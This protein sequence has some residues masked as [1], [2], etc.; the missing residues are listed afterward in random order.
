MSRRCHANYSQSGVTLVELMV[1]LVLG[2][3]VLGAV[4]TVFLSNSRT[5]AATESLG[6]FQENARVAFELMARDVREAAGNPCSRNLPVYNVLNA[7]GSVWYT[8]FTAGVRGYPG[9]VAFP[10]AAFGTGAGQ[11]IA[12]TDAVELKSAV[13]D[14]VAIVSHDPNSAQFK[15]STANHGLSDGD[16]ALACDFGQAAIFQVTNAQPG[17]NDTLV[18]NNGVGTPGNC[19]KGLGWSATQNCSANGNSYAFGCYMGAWET[20]DCADENPKDGEPDRWPATIA[21]LRM[22]RWYIGAN[23]R[24]GRSL[25]R[26]SLRNT[27]GVLGIQQD[28]ITEGV[29]DME[30]TYLVDGAAQYVDASSVAA[31]DWTSNNVIAM[32]IDLT[33]IGNEPVGTDGSPLQRRLIHVVTIR[34]RNR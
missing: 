20:G 10:D 31:S 16:L 28:E 25:Y 2:L 14:G 32:R 17:I 13:A 26:S 11:R 3:I 4:T 8:D 15:L 27:G 9:T 18:H 34:N 6:R 5:Y 19:S 24:G 33:L 7:P 1:A 29:R 12:G 30:L 22:S 21:R 23:T